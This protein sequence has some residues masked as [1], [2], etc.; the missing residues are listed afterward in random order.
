V[1]PYTLHTL[2]AG[3]PSDLV[4]VDS[5]KTVLS[6]CERIV[7]L[8]SRRGGLYMRVHGGMNADDIIKHTKKEKGKMQRAAIKNGNRMLNGPGAKAALQKSVASRSSS[9]RQVRELWLPVL[10]VQ[11]TIIVKDTWT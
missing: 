8:V 2:V 6:E 9:M 11:K 10:F 7:S 5:K 4:A 1:R 3:T